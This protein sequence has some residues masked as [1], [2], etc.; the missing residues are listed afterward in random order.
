MKIFN[1]KALYQPTGKAAEYSPWAVNFY[2]GCSNDCEYCYCK[3]GVMS[4]VW[5]NKPHLKKC[6]RNEEHALK[7]FVSEL[8]KNHEAVKKHGVLFSFTTDPLLPETRALT[9]AAVTA[10]QCV[11][12]PVQI[13]TKCAIFPEETPDFPNKDLIAIGF[14]LTGFDEK[15]PG[16]SLNSERIEAMQEIYNWGFHT[17]AS[18]EPVITP[19]M[20][21]RMIEQT[22]DFCELYKIGLMSGVSKDFYKSKDVKILWEYLEEMALHNYKI[23]P[24]DSLLAYLGVN[25]ADLKHFVHADYNLFKN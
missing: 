11:D 22:H 25:R 16:A 8:F 1:G 24:K 10:C 18:I 14:T 4:H 9:W 3:R 7:V 6:F 19:A 2:T 13:L 12:V 15:E 21:I 5:D 20:S 17:F 23:Y